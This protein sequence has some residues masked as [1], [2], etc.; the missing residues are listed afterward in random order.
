MAHSHTNKTLFLIVGTHV[1]MVRKL[2]FILT[3]IPTRYVYLSIT[4]KRL[5]ENVAAH[6]S[7][8]I[9]FHAAECCEDLRLESPMCLITSTAI[10]IGQ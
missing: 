9:K 6:M 7:N 5:T 1:R 2:W 3:G 10:S 8:K 4:E